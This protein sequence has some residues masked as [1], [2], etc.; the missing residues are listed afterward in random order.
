MYLPCPEPPWLSR[1]RS[2]ACPKRIGIRDTRG[3]SRG[4][5]DSGL[6][7]L[8]HF[9]YRPSGTGR[10]PRWAIPPKRIGKGSCG[11]AVLLTPPGAAGL[12]TETSD[13]NWFSG[14]RD[15]HL[16]RTEVG[17]LS[18]TRHCRTKHSYTNYQLLSSNRRSAVEL[19]HVSL[20]IRV[21]NDP[22]SSA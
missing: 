17:T 2:C 13:R 18:R 14:G 1:A 21:G 20:H 19:P 9:R 10:L 8:P 16:A 4:S 12:F 22:C 7:A 15:G 5:P 6:Q 3:P 11:S